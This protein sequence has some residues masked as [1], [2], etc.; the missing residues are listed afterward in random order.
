MR[1]GVARQGP[2]APV[3]AVAASGLPTERWC[4]E[5]FLPRKGSARAGRLA[6]L[7]VEE[8]TMVLFESPHRLAA[9]LADLLTVMGGGR[10]VVVARE[11]T[12][13][14]EEFWR[15]TL[16]EAV[17]FASR[18]VKGEVVVVV[19]G[20]PPAAEADDDRIRVVLAEA[21]SAG[22]STRDAADEAARR[23]GVSRRRAYRLALE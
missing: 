6:E 4:M 7:S 13:L 21:L 23:L 2:S 5:G 17:V 11:M 15:G 20:S 1:L 10:Q 9:T 16:D 22:A 18:P 12:K 19:A 14:H 8:R 3:A